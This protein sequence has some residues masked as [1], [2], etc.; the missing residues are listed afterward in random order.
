[1]LLLPS[2]GVFKVSRL[3]EFV[4][5]F[6]YFVLFSFFCFVFVFSGAKVKVYFG[7]WSKIKSN[8]LI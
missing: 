3:L 2:V 8:G 1:M 6:L 7:Q 4:L 5:G